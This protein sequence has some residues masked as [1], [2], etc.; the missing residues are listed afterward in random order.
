[1]RLYLVRHGEAAPGEPDELRQLTPEGRA[2]ARALGERLRKDG[3]QPDAVLTSPLL[4][5]R[6]TG[7]ELARNLGVEPE[8]DDRLAPGATLEDVRAAV[9]GRGERVVAVGHQPDCGRVAAALTGREPT[10]PAGSMVVLEL[11]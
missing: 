11:E 9:A 3:V 7:T 5:A 4:R 8:P 10:F 6:E 1:M 2:Q